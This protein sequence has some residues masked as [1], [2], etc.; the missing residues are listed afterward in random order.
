MSNFKNPDPIYDH[1]HPMVRGGA[2]LLDWALWLT[3][4]FIL[5]MAFLQISAMLFE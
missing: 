3:Y 4:R 1:P 5:L 2:W